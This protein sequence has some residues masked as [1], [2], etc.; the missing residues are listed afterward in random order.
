MG[1]FTDNLTSSIASG[2]GNGIV[3]MGLNAI[4]GLFG[5]GEKIANKQYERELEKMKYQAQLNKENAEYSLGLQKDMWDYTNYENQLKHLKEAG[6]NPALM[7]GKG[8]AGGS[9]NAGSAAAEGVSQGVTQSIGMGLQY[10]QMQANIELARAQANKAN[11]EA[12]KT[13]G[14]DTELTESEIG[15]N[16]ALEELKKADTNVSNWNAKKIEAEIPNVKKSFEVLAQNLRK[17]TTEA[18]IAEETKANKI[19]ESFHQMQKTMFEGLAAM[20]Q[21]RLNEQTIENLK[22]EFNWIGYKYVTGRISA[23]AAEKSAAA[24]G[25]TATAAAERAKSYNDY[26]ES[27]AQ[28]VTGELERWDKALTQEDTRILQ[29]WIFNTSDEVLKALDIISSV[30]SKKKMIVEALEGLAGKGKSSGNTPAGGTAAG[31]PSPSNEH[32]ASG[33]NY[34]WTGTHRDPNSVTPDEYRELLRRAKEGDTEA[35]KRLLGE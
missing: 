10:E 6:L 34:K 27:F 18:D 16:K 17:V 5:R 8:G 25:V 9:G 3:G 7:Y 29:A 13:S 35:I 26:V 31:S 2:I 28:R 15:L 33:R 11:A 14:V 23:N 21:G 22:Q 20:T 32:P 30:V 12:K 19:N 1:S 24:A 4:S